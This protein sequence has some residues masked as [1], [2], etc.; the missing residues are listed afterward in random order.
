MRWLL[1]VLILRLSATDLVINVEIVNKGEP[2]T[3]SIKTAIEEVAGVEA[4]VATLTVVREVNFVPGTCMPGYYWTSNSTCALCACV[5][6]P[7]RAKY[8][9]FAPLTV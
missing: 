7:S 6:V 5:P 4:Q 8:V 3:G 9:N 1:I 2:A